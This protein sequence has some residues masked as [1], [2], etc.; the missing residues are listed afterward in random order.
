M[1]RVSGTSKPKR[2]SHENLRNLSPSHSA[3]TVSQAQTCARYKTR[4]IHKPWRRRGDG[5]T[6]FQ[7][8]TR[9]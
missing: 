7:I 2:V 1:A 9:S 8:K 3:V 5:L 6:D 4:H